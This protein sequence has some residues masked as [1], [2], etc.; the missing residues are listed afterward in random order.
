M[1]VCEQDNRA[2]ECS[3]SC[4]QKPLYEK[5]YSRNRFGDNDNISICLIECSIVLRSTKLSTTSNGE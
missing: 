5:S 3:F 4:F 1:Y 2:G